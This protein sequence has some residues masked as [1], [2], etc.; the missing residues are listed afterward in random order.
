MRECWHQQAY[1]SRLK[2]QNKKVISSHV[3]FAILLITFFVC[4]NNEISSN[5]FTTLNNL[6]VK[7]SMIHIFLETKFH[8]PIGCFFVLLCCA[9]TLM[10][11]LMPIYLSTFYMVRS[12]SFRSFFPFFYYYRFLITV[13][14]FNGNGSE[15]QSREYKV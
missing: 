14:S 5:V 6:I 4:F 9:S 12:S 3:L 2:P 15:F 8:L 13:F 1:R 7:I 11:L 10:Y